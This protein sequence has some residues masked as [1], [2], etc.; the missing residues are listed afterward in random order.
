MVYQ[1]NNLISNYIYPMMKV[2]HVCSEDATPMQNI[3]KLYKKKFKKK[4]VQIDMSFGDKSVKGYDVVHGHY[5][6]TKPVIDANRKARKNSIPF[7]LHS[8]GSDVRKVMGKGAVK[9]PFHHLWISKHIR[10]KSDM[11]LLSTPDLEEWAEGIYLPNPVDLDMF[12]PLDVEK[13]GKILLLGR[14]S[15]GGGIK[16]VLDPEK[17]YDCINWGDNI[18]FPDNVDTLPFLEHDELPE[19]LN[20]YEMMIGP[21]VDPVSLARLEAM[22]CGLKTYTDFPKKYTSYYG[23]ENPDEVKDPRRFVEKYHDPDKITG[24]LL[25]IY[26]SLV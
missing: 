3:I 4:N 24:Y 17:Q 14:F 26:E 22:A 18:K 19:L 1:K 15:E 8:H 13:T 2:L 25:D 10:K 5:A 16:K 11:V 7:I 6:L 9:L 23:F 21:L 20:R 12:K